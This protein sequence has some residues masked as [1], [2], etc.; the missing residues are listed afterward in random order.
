[1][2]DST[3]ELFDR[4]R[5][6]ESTF[7]EVEEVRFAGNR[8]S[9][10]DPDTLADEV[11]AFANS[12]GGVFVFGVEDRTREVVGIPAERLDTVVDFIKEVCATSM[13]PPIEDCALDRL[14]LPSDAGEDVPVIKVEIAVANAVAHRDYPVHGSKSRLRL[15]ADRLEN[16]SPGAIANPLAI[17]SLRNRQSARNEAVCSLLAKCPAPDESWLVTDRTN[18]MDRRG[19]GVPVIVDNS[20]RLS[21]KEPRYRLIDDAELHL[22]IYAPTPD[23][24][25]SA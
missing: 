3:K 4:I 16:Y 21:G 14:W 17:D 10:P 13:D 18:I 9:G 25:G 5:L 12:R 24:A 22:T 8:V 15:F 6:G 7:L 11:A 19:E 20:L 23:R 2:F 1:M